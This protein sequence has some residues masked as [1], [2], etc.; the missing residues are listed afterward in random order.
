MTIKEKEDEIIEAFDELENWENR[1]TYLLDL[2]RDLK[3]YPEK[4]KTPDRKIEGCQSNVWLDCEKT[5]DGNLVFRADADS[6]IVKGIVSMLIDVFS[7]HTPDEILA[8]DLGFINRIGLGAQ[9]SPTRSNGLLAMIKQMRAY[10]AA[11]R[12][13]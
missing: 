9:L 7:D 4:L 13:A 2:A 8:D 10:A 5:P 6:L 1:Y 11:F 12:E 3:P